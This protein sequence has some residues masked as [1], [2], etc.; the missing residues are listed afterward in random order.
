MRYGRAY[1]HYETAKIETSKV[2]NL[3]REE[4]LKLFAPKNFM[5][6]LISEQV[7]YAPILNKLT[8]SNKSVNQHRV[9]RMLNALRVNKWEEELLWDIYDSQISTGDKFLEVYFTREDVIPRLRSLDSKKMVDIL[10]DSY[11]RP[12][13]YIYK[14][15]VVDRDLTLL[16]D[17]A[18]LDTK[19]QREVTWVFERGKTTILDSNKILRTDAGEVIYDDN[20]EAKIKAV[21][22]PNPVEFSN[23]FLLIHIPSLKRQGEVFSEIIATRVIDDCIKADQIS[24]DINYDNRLAG[25]PVTHAINLTL[26]ALNSSRSPG[27]VINWDIKDPNI[28]KFS[29]QSTEISNDLKSLEMEQS[30]VEDDLYRKMYLIR[31]KLELQFGS[32]DSSRTLQQARLSL[33]KF[34]KKLTYSIN[35]SMSRYFDLV[36]KAYGYKKIYKI[37]FIV[38]DPILENTVFDK[39]L[40][41]MQELNAGIK[42][43]PDVWREMGL[44][45][46]EIKR[47]EDEHNAIYYE[48]NKDISIS[49][50]DDVGASGGEGVKGMDNNFK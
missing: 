42:T 39:L 17:T 25:F 50:P 13:A 26:D 30:I 19:T 10:T 22:K 44:S 3:S 31:P 46:S 34:L 5:E 35:T 27:G 14:Q 38:P 8:Y 32:S 33:E 45:Q 18:R 12:K 6:R 11:G 29:L 20:G 21:V 47:R 16:G 4:R 24:S 40:Q 48:N 9:N 23:E 28:D 41:W 15:I 49:K 1:E 36:Q 37:E 43:L 2:T 7:N